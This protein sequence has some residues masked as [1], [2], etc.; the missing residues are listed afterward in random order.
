[1]LPLVA[2]PDSKACSASCTVLHDDKQRGFSYISFQGLP[3]QLLFHHHE[4]PR[5]RNLVS[6]YEDNYNRRGCN[7]VLPALRVWNGHKLTWIPQKS[8]FPILGSFWH[9]LFHQM[10]HG[11]VVNT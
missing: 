4:E 5:S 10:E 2:Q 6:E 9:Y 3:L 8:D 1:M 7:T 11:A